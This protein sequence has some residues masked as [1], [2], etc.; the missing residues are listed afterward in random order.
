ML[1]ERPPKI[2]RLFF[3]GCLF[4]MKG[5]RRE[6]MLTFDDGPIPE[7]T[8][9]I[10]DI[11][12]R[13]GIKATFFMVGDNVRKH[14]EVFEEVK[15]RGHCIGNHSMHH[16]QG[17][18]CRT[19]NYMADIAEADAFIG[20]PYYRPPHG[21]LRIPQR[22]RVKEKYHLVMYDLVTRDYSKKVGAEEVLANVKRL[23]RPGSVIVFHDSLR[24]I[25]KLRKILPEALEW[26]ISQ[27]YTFVT[28]EE[29]FSREAKSKR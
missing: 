2:F 20:S 18:L 28:A 3:P 13:Y 29:Y 21:F 19:R 26:I 14:P 27:G 5:K 7:A 9:E 17:I 16:V 8:P 12:D 24:S 4:R 1:I 22:R 25:E 23:T 10:L 15:R 6:V 11:L